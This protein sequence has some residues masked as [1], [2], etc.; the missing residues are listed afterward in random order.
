MK[1]THALLFAAGLL[2]P[3]SVFL[4]AD[5]GTQTSQQSH[6]DFLRETTAR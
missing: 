4:S 3:A 2:L 5:D 6:E 1:T